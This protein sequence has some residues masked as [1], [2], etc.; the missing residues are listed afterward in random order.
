[1]ISYS[2]KDYKK[3]RDNT[4]DKAIEFWDLCTSSAGSEQWEINERRFFE[5]IQ[6]ERDQAVEN[7]VNMLLAARPVDIDAESKNSISQFHSK[8]LHPELL[9]SNP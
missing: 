8:Y 4:W 2:L 6:K 9:P 3:Q 5:L 7:F 1:M